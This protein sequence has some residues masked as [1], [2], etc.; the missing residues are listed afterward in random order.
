MLCVSVMIRV[1]RRKEPVITLLLHK[2]PPLVE[3]DVQN[4]LTSA[5]LRLYC[6]VM[7]QKNL[8][9]TLPPQPLCIDWFQLSVLLLRTSMSLLWFGSDSNKGKKRILYV[10]FKKEEK[11]KIFSRND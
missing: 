7:L 4:M 8:T 5:E 10:D 1:Y 6:T 2:L 11:T 9:P 3:A